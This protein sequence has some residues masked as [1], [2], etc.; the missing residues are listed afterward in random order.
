MAERAE[1]SEL[2]KLTK[3]KIRGEKPFLT[4][5]CIHVKDIE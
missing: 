5:M 4:V 3:R 2:A 1:A